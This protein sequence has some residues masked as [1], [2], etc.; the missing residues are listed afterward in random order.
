MYKTF[1]NT[2]KTSARLLPK[3]VNVWFLF[4]SHSFCGGFEGVQKIGLEEL[5][6]Q[7]IFVHI[8]MKYK[9]WANEANP[10]WKLDIAIENRVFET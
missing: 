2:Y 6:K 7:A 3:Y 8:F 1:V 5:H 10:S 4:L 9:F